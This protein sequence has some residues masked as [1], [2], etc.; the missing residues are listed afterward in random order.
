MKVFSIDTSFSEYYV[1]A[2]NKKQAVRLTINYSKNEKRD[3]IA[4]YGD[5]LEYDCFKEEIEELYNQVILEK[6]GVGVI[7]ERRL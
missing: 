3:C 5:M 6:S 7:Y 2:K 4:N 1:M